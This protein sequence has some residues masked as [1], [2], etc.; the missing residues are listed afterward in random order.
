VRER[1]AALDPQAAAALRAEDEKAKKRD[2][3]NE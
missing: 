1:E 2:E 3:F